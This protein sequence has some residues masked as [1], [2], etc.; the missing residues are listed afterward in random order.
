MV[1]FTCMTLVRAVAVVFNR[2]AVELLIIKVLELNVVEAMLEI[3]ADVVR[4]PIASDE[5]NELRV[6]SNRG[7][8]VFKVDNEVRSV[9]AFNELV[10]G[11]VVLVTDMT[12]VDSILVVL[13]MVVLPRTELLLKV[14][15]TVV[16][17]V[18]FAVESDEFDI[19]VFKVEASVF[20][21]FAV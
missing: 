14:G 9:V 3:K 15:T 12:R 17:V 10:I 16:V 5:F 6:I 19:L 8:V 4:L 7:L 11:T 13:V 21:V 20:D 1:I 2:L 18:R